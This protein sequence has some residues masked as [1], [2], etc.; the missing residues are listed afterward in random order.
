MKPLINLKSFLALLL[1]LI[2][3]T[4]LLVAYFRNYSTEGAGH[5]HSEKG[6]EGG[7]PMKINS[8]MSGMKSGDDTNAA[9]EHGN[10]A[11]PQGDAK[12]AAE[13]AE[14]PAAKPAHEH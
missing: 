7:V 2:V 3:S 11:I 5:E 10:M 1:I 9:S 4:A 14:E 8:G 12:P 6:T 13:P